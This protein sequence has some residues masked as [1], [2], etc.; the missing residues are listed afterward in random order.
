MR[1]GEAQPFIKMIDSGLD[2]TFQPPIGQAYMQGEWQFIVVDTDGWGST[3]TD[4]P[5]ADNT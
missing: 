4:S 1:R 3:I 2:G 5:A